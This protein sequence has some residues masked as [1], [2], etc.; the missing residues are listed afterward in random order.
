MRK[1]L[2]SI[3]IVVLVMLD[4]ALAAAVVSPLVMNLGTITVTNPPAPNDVIVSATLGTVNGTI[5]GNSV[6][7]ANSNMTVGDVEPL[8]VNVE[9]TG[10]LASNITGILLSGFVNDGSVITFDDG[11]VYPLVMLSLTS[12]SHPFFTGSQKHVDTA[13]RIEKFNKK[14]KI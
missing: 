4:V 2:A 8:T 6:L 3:V 11:N 14:F 7:F 5:H 13:G 9:N 12:D 10:N 1:K